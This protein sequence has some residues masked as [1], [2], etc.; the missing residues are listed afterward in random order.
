MTAKT[1][2]ELVEHSTKLKRDK[3]SDTPYLPNWNNSGSGTMPQFLSD[4][5]HDD[6]ARADD[7]RRPPVEPGEWRAD[8]VG[9][10]P[11]LVRDGE[12][13]PEVG[14]EVQQVPRLV[15]Q[16]PPGHAQ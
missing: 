5:E 1:W 11:H 7:V 9:A 16:P 10:G 8:E 12:A 15:A 6:G 13:D 3:I 4:A 2:D 14:V